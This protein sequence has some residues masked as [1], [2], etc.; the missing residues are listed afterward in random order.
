MSDA[1]GMSMVLSVLVD[2]WRSADGS[3]GDETALPDVMSKWRAMV[4]MKEGCDMWIVPRSRSRV[5]LI[6]SRR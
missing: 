1:Y 4:L 2:E 5:I 3:M 6:P